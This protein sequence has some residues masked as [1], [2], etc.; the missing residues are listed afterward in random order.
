MSEKHMHVLNIFK[1]T[2]FHLL[3]P[4]GLGCKYYFMYDRDFKIATTFHSYGLCHIM[5]VA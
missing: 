4:L 5:C 2:N 1:K 3:L